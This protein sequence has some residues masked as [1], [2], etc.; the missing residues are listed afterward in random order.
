MTASDTGLRARLD[1]WREQGA[2]RTEPLRFGMIAALAQRA[3]RYHGPVRQVLQDRLAAL[4]DDFANAIAG[5]TAETPPAEDNPAPAPSPLQDLLAHIGAARKPADRPPHAP[6]AEAP[7]TPVR[8][9]LPIL[10]EF[11]QLWSRI[12]TDSQLR[13]SLHAAPEDAGPLHSSTLLHRA[14]TL[15]HEA[16]PGYLQ[17]FIAYADA[18]SWMEQLHDDGV[19]ETHAASRG[20]DVKTTAKPR[21]RKRT[22]PQ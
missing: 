17:H 9:P 4:V 19:L 7:S 20:G 21:A 2:D 6:D 1:A 11:Q 5:T 13:Q 15:M 14:M 22:K 12:R 10:D 16:S 3:D 18:L 8:T